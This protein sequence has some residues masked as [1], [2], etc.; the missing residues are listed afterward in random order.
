MYLHIGNGY[1]VREDE[2]IGIFDLDNTS[3]S[4]LTR[5]YLKNA[6]RSGSVINAADMELPKSFVVRAGE[7]GQSVYLS[8]LNPSTLQK[9]SGEM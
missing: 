9:R 8:Q 1:V 7:K 5:D 2:I 6:E 4:Y 3:Q